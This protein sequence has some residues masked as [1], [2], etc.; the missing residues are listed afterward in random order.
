MYIYHVYILSTDISRAAYL[1]MKTDGTI[2]NFECKHCIN[3]D[4]AERAIRRDYVMGV[5][6]TSENRLVVQLS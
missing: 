4:E 2:D 5:S 1:K 3:V 6:I